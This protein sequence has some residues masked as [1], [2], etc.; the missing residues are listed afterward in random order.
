MEPSAFAAGSN[1]LWRGAEARRRPF[2]IFLSSPGDVLQERNIVGDVVSRLKRTYGDDRVD[3][4]MCDEVTYHA[5]RT[6]Q[7][8][9]PSPAGY[10]VFVV[11]LGRRI[12]TF[13][14]N[15][16]GP[17]SGGEVTGTEFEFET[18]IES[19]ERTGRP[20]PI[21]YIRRPGGRL[22]L[23]A[24]SPEAVAA[25]AENWQRLEAFKERWLVDVGEKGLSTVSQS[26]FD[27]RN[28]R[29]F[30]EYDPE[31][32]EE[33]RTRIHRDLTNTLENL[34][35]IPKAEC[36]YVGLRAFRYDEC[37]RLFGRLQ[38]VCEM[39]ERLGI[40]AK[41]GRGF[42]AVYGASG[43]GK[44]SVVIAGLVPNL[45][46]AGT[47]AGHAVVGH[48]VLRPSLRDTSGLVASLYRTVGVACG[49]GELAQFLVSLQTERTTESDGAGYLKRC[50]QLA[51]KEHAGVLQSGMKPVIV[52]VID[53][54]E[55]LFAMDEFASQLG[56]FFA[57][58]AI[59]ASS[60]S[61]WVVM[62]IRV[63]YVDRLAAIPEMVEL[64]LQDGSYLLRPA[65]PTELRQIIEEP[66]RQAGLE[67]EYDPNLGR[68][69]ADRLCDDIQSTGMGSGTLP[70]LS[71]VLKELWMRR[72]DDGR[73]PYSTYDGMN[74]FEG[75]IETAA[76]AAYAR[77]DARLRI[78][79][80]GVIRAFVSLSTDQR[81]S[82]RLVPISHFHTHEE[83]AIVTLFKDEAVRMFVVEGVPGG[84]AFVTIAHEALLRRWSR[85]KS[86]IDQDGA[87]LRI[88]RNFDDR[89]DAYE[90]TQRALHCNRVNTDG[91]HG[92]AEP[93][94]NAELLGTATEIAN[95]RDV[96]RKRADFLNPRT[97][98]FVLASLNADRE[99]RR[100]HALHASADIGRSSLLRLEHGDLEGALA[101]A[102]RAVES[103]FQEDREFTASDCALDTL[104]RCVRE[105]RLRNI[106]RGHGVAAVTTVR[107]SPDG[108]HVASGDDA[109]M[110]RIWRHSDLVDKGNV[111]VAGP[112]VSMAWR[113]D[114]KALAIRDGNGMLHI[115]Y[116]LTDHVQSRNAWWLGTASD[117]G[118]IAFGSDERTVWAGGETLF[119]VTIDGAA[120]E[121]GVRQIAGAPKEVS[122][123]AVI[124]APGLV[125]GELVAVTT[126][127]G[128]YWGFSVVEQRQVF[129]F[130]LTAEETYPAAASPDGQRLATTSKGKRVYVW[131]TADLCRGVFNAALRSPEFQL[132]ASDVAFAPDGRVVAASSFDRTVR[133]FEYESGQLTTLTG[134]T[135][136]VNSV[137]WSGQR[138][139]SGSIDGTVRV[140][141]A[142]SPFE[143][144]LLLGHTANVKYLEFGW[145]GRLLVSCA[146]DGTIRLYEPDGSVG[147][148]TTQVLR[149]H[150]KLD[151][152]C[153]CLISGD[154]FLASAS[155]DRTVRVWSVELGRTI[156]VLG[157]HENNVR[158]VSASSSGWIAS[159]CFDG[160]VRIWRLEDIEAALRASADEPLSI[161]PYCS[162]CPGVGMVY[163]LA[164]NPRGDELAVVGEN[165][166]LVILATGI[167]SELRRVRAHGP[168]RETPAARR[169]AI[170]GAGTITNYVIF[171]PDGSMIA[172]AADDHTAKLWNARTLD[173]AAVFLGH[174]HW[175]AQVAFHPDGRSVATTSFD[176]TVRIWDLAG[177]RIATLRGHT[178]HAYALAFHPDGK[179][180]FTG[181]HDRTI[182]IWSL[183]LDSA[184]ILSIARAL[185]ALVTGAEG[186]FEACCPTG[187]LGTAPLERPPMPEG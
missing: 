15:K 105:N 65:T 79:F 104:E 99:R 14:L 157:G 151:I 138:I 93:L 143:P 181:G 171:S 5:G 177:T 121:L 55:E 135:R 114:G 30:C 178:N 101:D 150:S 25:A 119:A 47:V 116:V 124:R 142:R 24:S 115:V 29:A 152:R 134:H 106:Y 53:Q 8:N 9:I 63:D 22:V 102:L 83:K 147:W 110:V 162:F 184:R 23:D 61:I 164:F 92:D 100:I 139:V 112:I 73:I 43:V 174:E 89:A 86:L 185:R 88:V 168:D 40:Q 4:F 165:G 18:A 16:K 87:W 109:G 52:V 56:A 153:V 158:S 6:Y 66:A 160:K 81:A 20:V 35:P 3:F 44:S 74:G 85:V 50:V 130:S 95:A 77:L 156:A 21:V 145:E 182:R 144:E 48:A 154:R 42:L 169:L 175:V 186:Q 17:L 7:D 71:F 127:Q 38:A 161:S 84:E 96:L 41:R 28:K 36:P 141:Y 172:T 166:D 90:A 51:V 1:E 140:W 37:S 128:L 129:C 183:D 132:D 75:A 31:R 13:L 179:H 155:W 57:S 46:R 80:P 170:S 97:Q 125:E 108:Y 103:V 27:V 91:A 163:S 45:E 11:I 94:A 126:R 33:F 26:V 136:W 34:R 98:R 148:R 2:R 72:Q 70:I 82:A 180:L 62:T 107:A 60:G 12:G 59:L 19:F 69:L 123:L 118:Q 113:S 111:R 64:G 68:T 137:D 58:L 10:D 149:G 122:G 187:P 146:D 173:T 67:F 176:R 76:E 167:W 78:A 131:H 49:D 54:S 117:Y 159:G 32:M 120:D 39:T 133:L